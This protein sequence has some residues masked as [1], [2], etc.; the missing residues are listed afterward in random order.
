MKAPLRAYLL[1]LVVALVIPLIGTLGYNVLRDAEDTLAQARAAQRP[2]AASIAADLS[3]K[4]ASTHETLRLIAERPRVQAMD[5][6]QCDSV[7]A[8]L[9]TLTPEY[10]N[11]VYTDRVGN[12]LC[13]AVPLPANRPVNVGGTDWFQ[14]V[15]AE[16]RFSVGRPHIGPIT[17]KWVSVLSMPVREPGGE[18]VGAVHLPLN[19]RAFRPSLGSRELPPDSRYGIIGIDGTLIW[20]N[21]DPGGL[22]GTRPD[23]A[24]A[25]KIAEM[26]SGDFELAG[27]DGI[28]RYYSTTPI[29][30]TDWV[31]FFGVPSAPIAEHTRSRALTNAALGMFII[32]GLVLF[33][34]ALA[35][36]IERPIGS[37]RQAVQ[38]FSQGGQGVLAE[39]SGPVELV[40]LATGFNT[41]VA[42]RLRIEAE[43]DAQRR[44]LQAAKDRIDQAMLIAQ[45]GMWRWDLPTQTVHSDEILARIFGYTPDEMAQLPVDTWRHRTHPDDLRTLDRSLRICLKGVTEQFEAAQRIRHKDGRWI[46]GLW[47]GRVTE[48]DARGRALTMVGSFHDVTERMQS[49]EKLQLAASV[50]THAREGIMITDP[51]GTIIDV[52]DTFTQITGY[53]REEALGNNPRMLQSGRQSP[54]FYAALWRT[55]TA[56]GHWTGEMWNRRKDGSLFAEIITISAVHSASGEVQH[57]VSLFTDIT[58][59][60]E[61]ERQLEHVAH[62][63]ALTGLPNRVLLADRLQQSMLRCQ[64]TGQSLAVAFLDLDGFKSVNDHHGHERGDEL[65]VALAH[66][67]KTALRDGDTLSRIGGDEFVAVLVDLEHAQDCEP[68]LER[69]LHA[70]ADPMHVGDALLQVSASIGVTLYPTDGVEPDLLIR[71]ADQAMYLAKQAGKNRYHLFDVAHDTAVKTQREEIDRIRK[72]LAREEF[73]LHYQPKVNMRTGVVLGAEALIRWQHPERGLLSPA[74]FLPAMAGHAISIEV[75]E[76]V[77]ATALRQ[78]AQW[79]TEGLDLAVSVNID[80]LQ[81]QTEGFVKRL[82][83]L[84]AAQPD[85]RPDRLELEILETSALEDI[86]HVSDI[87]H[88]CQAL[89]VRFALDDFGTG[90]SSLTYLKR[91][92]AEVIKIDQSFVRDMQSDPDDLAI[93]RGVIGLADAF[94]R[95]VIAEGVETIAHGSLL[96][97]LGCEQAQGYGIARPMP[98]SELPGWVRHW[99]PDATWTGYGIQI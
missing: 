33:A 77:L 47:R 61:N 6:L 55:L 30:E 58:E 95:E 42:D 26:R 35:R 73:V 81:L 7:L 74:S 21:E 56:Q 15:M 27:I 1:L 59:I 18:V 70:A 65:L 13:S 38:E 84:L 41:M 43:L 82:A 39:P 20:R 9:H 45:M 76:W 78:M 29:P 88:R 89:G 28:A 60:K 16:Q 68:V 93:V 90:Y 32:L 37:L 10:S 36:R 96:I 34:L 92:N 5:P 99:K 52:N 94:R 48:R 24:T 23:W 44:E 51:R 87:M 62:Y 80:A 69:M 14:K 83:E 22:I 54:E 67:L 53:T 4:I 85:V 71:H 2:L 11:I 57:Y 31:A 79:R 8:D 97:P 12:T 66:R 64:R 98:A 50:F 75:G 40:E 25:S 19:L 72:A 86:A 17:G 91:L 46:W 3:R 49:H 63:D